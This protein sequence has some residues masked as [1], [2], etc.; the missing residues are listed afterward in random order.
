MRAAFRCLQAA[1]RRLI[2]RAVE[3]PEQCIQQLLS[4]KGYYPGYHMNKKSWCSIIFDDTLPDEE[5]QARIAE[6]Y[7]SV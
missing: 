4:E 1:V 6:S 5:I 7:K 3:P 2:G